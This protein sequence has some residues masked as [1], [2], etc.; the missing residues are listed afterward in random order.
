MMAPIIDAPENSPEAAY[1][2]KQMK[3]RSLIKQ[4]NGLLKMHFRCLLKHR[5]LHYSPPTAS[6]IIYT[7]A[8]L[9]NICISKNVPMPLDLNDDIEEFDFGIN[10]YTNNYEE[11]N[12]SE[13]NIRRINP[14]LAAGRLKQRQIIRNYF[15]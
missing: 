8:V 10:V 5:V 12:V 9:H 3:V 11:N 14:D 1:N 4:C 6:K 7:C 15:S 13:M 2:K